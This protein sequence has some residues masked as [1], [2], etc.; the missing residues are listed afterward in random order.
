[1]EYITKESL[2]ELLENFEH[3]YPEAT[4]A[5]RVA[6]AELPEGLVRCRNCAAYT[7]EIAGKPTSWCCCH[8][9]ITYPNDFCSD[10]EPKEGDE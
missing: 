2:Y 9:R 4:A 3:L 10:G 1:M 6:V 8:E 7:T 5:F